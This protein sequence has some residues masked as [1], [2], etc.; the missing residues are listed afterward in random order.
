MA[1]FLDKLFAPLQGAVGRSQ[2][3]VANRQY[4][5]NLAQNNPTPQSGGVTVA[6]QPS[7]AP[8]TASAPAPELQPAVVPNTIPFPTFGT[9]GFSPVGLGSVDPSQS[10]EYQSFL[11][12]AELSREQAAAISARKRA[13]LEASLTPALQ[14]EDQYLADNM[15]DIT[16]NA[17][18]RGVVRGSGRLLQQSKAQSE[19]E[20]RKAQIQKGITDQTAQLADDLQNMELQ[21]QRQKAEAELQARQD[22]AAEQNQRLAQLAAQRNLQEYLRAVG[23]G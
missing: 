21:F 16:E 1:S 13:Q 11:R 12:G 20:R 6:Q 23:L 4:T 9:G 18:N 15:T 8:A 7:A 17:A 3:G 10:L 22:L 5:P 2:A 19:T 14:A